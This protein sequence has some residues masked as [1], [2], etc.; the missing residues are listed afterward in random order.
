VEHNNEGA[1]GAAQSAAEHGSALK[2]AATNQAGELASTVKEH[3]ADVAQEAKQ[4]G[5]EVFDKAK[6]ALHEQAQARTNEAS[7]AL[8]RFSNQVQA[9]AD[10]RPEQ[11]G[12]V[13]DYVRQAAGKVQNVAQRVEREGFDGVVHD[14][15]EFG[16]RRPGVFLAAAG[17]AGFVVGRMIRAGRESTNGR[18]VQYSA[19]PAPPAAPVPVPNAAMRAEPSMTP[20]QPIGTPR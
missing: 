14:V 17:V 7:Q 1:R 5:R 18:P 9:L 11:A 12:P 6:D 4:Q 15:A 19:I 3:A 13:G 16:R 20:T 10:G 8:R 2:D